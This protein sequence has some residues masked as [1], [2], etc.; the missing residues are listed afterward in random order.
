MSED[1]TTKTEALEDIVNELE[2]GMVA[3]GWARLPAR[4]GC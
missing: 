2:A 3:P 1:M 4:F